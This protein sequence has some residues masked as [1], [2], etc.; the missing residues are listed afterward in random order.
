MHGR[1]F[2][3]T[4]RLALLDVLALVELDFALAHAERDFHASVFPVERAGVLDYVA[5]WYLKSAQLITGTKEG[6]VS[7]DKHHYAEVTIAGQAINP[8]PIAL[9]KRGGGRASKRSNLAIDDLFVS[10][11]RVDQEARKRIRCAFVSTKS[12]IQGEQVGVLW[13]ELLRRRIKIHF[14]HR[15]FKWS[16]EAPGMAAV[17]CVIIG[18]AASDVDAKQIFEYLDVKGKPHAVNALNINPYLIDAPDI[19][20]SRRS[21]PIGDTARITYGSMALDDGHLTLSDQEREEFIQ[22]QPACQKYIQK[23]IGGEE[24]INNGSRWCLW[25]PRIEPLELKRLAPI[26]ERVER[27]R[28]YRKTS[29]RAATVKLANTPTLFGEN[30]QPTSDYILIPKVSSENRRFLPIGFCRADVIAS[31]SCLIVPDA[32]LYHF[33]VLSCSMHMAWM[34]YTCGRLEDRY[35]YSTTIVYNN[36][37]W[38]SDPPETQ[39]QKIES[40]AQ[41]VLDARAQFSDASLADLYDPLTMPPALSA[42]HQKLD[43]TVDAAY[44]RKEFKN[45]AERV[46]FL[47]TLYQMYTSFLPV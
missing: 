23:F 8:P 13:G 19:V 14:A 18:F 30:R 11:E 45:D 20:L 24:F 31:G 34:R 6:F 28:V 2:Q 21:V 43:A 36:F 33:G 9:A 3:I 35:Q 32:N 4:L 29:G 7:R 37:P 10:A 46:A 16:N 42:A 15:T 27:V 40:A 26:L 17:H 5:G 41:S 25:L 44:G 12:I 39:K 47:F 22:T 1:A 38:P